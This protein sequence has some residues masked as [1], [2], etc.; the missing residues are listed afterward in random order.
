MAINRLQASL[1]QATNEVTVA[2][3]N[4]NFDFTLVKCE[5][6]KEY[7][8]LGNT[9]SRKRKFEAETGQ[10]HITARR[11][12]ALF[13]GVCPATPNLIKAYGLRASEI[14]SNTKDK[15]SEPSNSIFAE[16]SGIDG[17][18]I[19]AAATSS[20]AAMHVQLLACMLA[21]IFDAQRATSI[22]YELV[23]DRK[24][25]IAGKYESGETLRFATLTAAAQSE[26]S[27]SSLADWDASARAWLRTADKVKN[28]AQQQLML[29]VANM[30]I[31]VSSDMMVFSSV[32][33]AWRSALESMEKLIGGM[34]HAANAGPPLLALSSWHLYPD[35]LAVGEKEVHVKFNDPLVSPGGRLTIGLDTLGEEGRGIHWSLSLAHLKFYGSPVISN[36]EYNVA[37][38]LTFLQFTYAVF[39]TVLKSWNMPPSSV[40]TVA[41]LFVAVEDF[42]VG[43]SQE[44][45]AGTN[46]TIGVREFPNN[47]AHWWKLL[48]VPARTLLSGTRDERDEVQRLINLGF[49]RSAAFL[50]SGAP[51]RSSIRPFFGLCDPG[52]FVRLMHSSRER[53]SF[54]RSIVKDCHKPLDLEAATQAS[55]VIRDCVLPDGQVQ[56]MTLIGLQREPPHHRWI[57]DQSLQVEDESSSLIIN[58]HTIETGRSQRQYSFTD[59]IT[60]SVHKVVSIFGDENTTSICQSPAAPRQAI[61]P[62]TIEALISCLDNG[63]I[64]ASALLDYLDTS[65]TLLDTLNATMR[66]MSAAFTFYRS[67]P[68]AT[69]STEVL[70]RPLTASSWAHGA[71]ERNRLRP[72][73]DMIN[74]DRCTAFSC[75]AYMEAC[76]DLSP[77]SFKS[78]FSL[79]YE[80]SLYI[81]MQVSLFQNQA[82]VE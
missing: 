58:H 1:A 77:E 17:T 49:R 6:P 79:A 22:W 24:C 70:N 15:F 74:L 50:S 72:Q 3:A 44:N 64:C 16:Q 62:L 14:A 33:P 28:N 60:G 32:I 34:P 48:S 68:D 73:M 78:I 10:A 2:A 61:P 82:M 13:E 35:L 57:S 41:K 31:P 51:G 26:I 27:R 4:I 59:T 80:D 53:I 12:G 67:L 81:A 54:L 65:L 36:G 25:E 7:H 38:R 20:P 75:I 69:L 39:G 63:L 46:T 9:L 29:I 47:R 8:G 21:R 55:L 66:A 5:A 76:A 40:K 23:K 43:A 56:Y 42:L 30:N 11:L 18:S 45:L 52:I 19:W 71:T 37:S